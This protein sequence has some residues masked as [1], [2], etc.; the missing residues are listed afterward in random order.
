MPI[1]ALP[2]GADGDVQA[3]GTH[4]GNLPGFKGRLMLI[5][6]TRVLAFDARAFSHFCTD[7]RGKLYVMRGDK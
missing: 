6:F 2:G 7:C 3:H 5:D 1:A 4:Q